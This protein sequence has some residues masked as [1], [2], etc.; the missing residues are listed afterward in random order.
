[1]L[2][3]DAIRDQY[4]RNAAGL[5]TLLLKAQ[6]SPSGKANGYTADRLQRLACA[7]FYWSTAT[8]EEL[9]AHFARFRK[10]AQTLTTGPRV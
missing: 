9:T 10:Y 7:Y 8:D 5:Q 4:A 6:S 3:F 1:M 2:R